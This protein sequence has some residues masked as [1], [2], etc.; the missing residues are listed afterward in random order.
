MPNTREEL[1]R[2]AIAE[3]QHRGLHQLSFRTLAQ[4]AGIK[5]SS[6]HY[7][8]PEKSDLA[9]AVIAQ[10]HAN[11]RAALEA[12]DKAGG[13][14]RD[15]LDALLDI[16][17]SVADE[18]R[19]CLCGMMAAD[20]SALSDE[21]GTL[22]EHYFLDL[23]AWVTNVVQQS[24]PPLRTDIPPAQLARIVVSGLEGALLLDRINHQRERLEAQRALLSS[25]F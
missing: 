9:A 16:F 7:H 21:S 1:K 25:F 19:H 10:Y 24:D 15:K 8:F 14:A 22:L 20:I 5:S 13:S 11:F 17:L 4:K 23:E 6:V 2:L 18:G 12:I 3:I